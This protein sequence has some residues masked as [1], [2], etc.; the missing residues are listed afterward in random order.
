MGDIFAATCQCGLNQRFKVGVGEQ[1]IESKRVP[2]Y[3]KECKEFL[4]LQYPGGLDKCPKC[5][6]R[7]IRYCVSRDNSSGAPDTEMYYYT[8]G[9]TPI[10]LPRNGNF[11][12]KCGKKTLKF[13]DAGS[14][15]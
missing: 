4:L 15:D 9:G 12:P 7:P 14:W 13:V 2:A 6:K 8:I 10:L 5:G 1:G 3:C 11:C